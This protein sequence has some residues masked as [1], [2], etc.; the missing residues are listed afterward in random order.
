MIWA[1]L[2]H[3]AISREGCPP[4]LQGFHSQEALE[5]V[6]THVRHLMGE[7]VMQF[8]ASIVRLPKLQAVQVISS[9]PPPSFPH[10]GL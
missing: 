1:W 3:K 4:L 8:D 9:S 7:A 10:L 5:M 6:K 2:R